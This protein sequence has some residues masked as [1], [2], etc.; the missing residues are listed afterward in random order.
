M[1]MVGIFPGKDPSGGRF[2][3]NAG[4]LGGI[5]VSILKGKLIILLVIYL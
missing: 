2:P 1:Y 4:N 3:A 5:M